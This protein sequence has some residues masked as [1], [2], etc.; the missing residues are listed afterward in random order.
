MSCGVGC[1]RGLDP[2]WLWL[3]NRPVAT[4]LM[5]PLAWEP[6]Y[7]EGAAL[8]KTKRQ[9]KKTKKKKTKQPSLALNQGEGHRH[10]LAG[11]G[12]QS[13]SLKPPQCMRNMQSYTRTFFFMLKIKYPKSEV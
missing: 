12:E 4:A 6:P 7:A 5:R 9:K 3:W 13:H 1:R 11:L 10:H 2:A 8:E